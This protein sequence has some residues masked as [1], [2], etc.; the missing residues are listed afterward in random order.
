MSKSSRNG[1]KNSKVEKKTAKADNSPRK[2]NADNAVSSKASQSPIPAA[3]ADKAKK[4]Q[5]HA[6]PAPTKKSKTAEQ[7]APADKAMVQE[8]SPVNK[9]ESAASINSRKNAEMRWANHYSAARK[10]VASDDLRSAVLE[11]QACVKFAQSLADYRLAN[12]F[13]E[14]GFVALKLRE[15]DTARSFIEFAIGVRETIYGANDPSVAIE[16]NNLAMTYEWNGDEKNARPHLE[17]AIDILEQ[18]GKFD[19]ANQAEPYEG[20]ASICANQGQYRLAE[21]LCLKAIQIRD[22]H[23]GRLHPLSMKTVQFLARIHQAAGNHTSAT[24]ANDVYEQRLQEHAESRSY[25]ATAEAL[26]NLLDSR[27]STSEREKYDTCIADFL[28]LM[29]R[30]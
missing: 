22:E 15:F 23:L 28:K 30:K 1:K 29:A 20:L 16:Y 14:L 11:L 26:R 24:A 17:K 4:A 7:A 25:G 19:N 27:D 8:A 9:K 2:A 10:A 18:H 12:S 5:E 13:A 6:A 21:Q 3:P